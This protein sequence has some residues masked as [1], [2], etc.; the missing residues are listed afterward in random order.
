MLPLAPIFVEVFDEPLRKPSLCLYSINGK[1]RYI[2]L[3]AFFL[4][5]LSIAI[6]LFAVYIKNNLAQGVANHDWEFEDGVCL[7]LDKRFFRFERDI[8]VLCPYIKPKA[9]TRVD[10]LTGPDEFDILEEKS[11]ELKNWG[12]IALL[13]D[14]NSRNRYH[15]CT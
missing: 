12:D 13:G 1:S 14:L 4:L 6:F 5:I 9:S 11:S 7:K 3:G 8:F 15:E 10:I 2:T